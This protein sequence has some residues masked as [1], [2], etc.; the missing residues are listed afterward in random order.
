MKELGP[1]VKQ[2][3]GSSKACGP[4]LSGQVDGGQVCARAGA[5]HWSRRPGAHHA[6][7]LGRTSGSN[8]AKGGHHWPSHCLYGVD[9]VAGAPGLSLLGW[10]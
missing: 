3:T 9:N 10:S 8:C 7:A 5:N 4:G 6:L 2:G 1:W